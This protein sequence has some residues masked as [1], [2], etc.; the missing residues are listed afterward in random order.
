MERGVWMLWRV[1]LRSLLS[2]PF[3]NL[4]SCL[5][6]R[7]HG[8]GRRV[9]QPL[10]QRRAVQIYT[11]FQYNPREMEQNPKHHWKTSFSFHCFFIR[12]HWFLL[13]FHGSYYWSSFPT[14]TGATYGTNQGKSEHLLAHP[15]RTPGAPLWVPRGGLVCDFP[16]ESVDFI[17]GNLMIFCRKSKG[18]HS[19]S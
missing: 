3:G 4:P 15:W 2:M 10:W 11:I 13:F 9:Q 6:G 7:I 1:P 19:V 18:S 5:H 12:F 8:R 17:S 14:N 16:F